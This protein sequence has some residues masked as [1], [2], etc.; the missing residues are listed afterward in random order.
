MADLTRVYDTPA[1]LAAQAA[2]RF[3]A[4]ASEAISVRGRFCVALAGGSTPKA[5][6]TDLSSRL[7]TALDWSKVE[8]YFGDERCVGPDHA[9]SNFLMTKTTLLAKLPIPTSNIHRIEGEKGPQA[10]AS[11]YET[12]LQ[13]RFSREDREAALDVTFLGMGG[14]G[15]TASLFPGHDFHAD[16]SRWVTTATAPP[17]SPIP[18]RVSL[19]IPFIARSRRV[20]FTIAGADKAVRLTEVMNARRAGAQKPPAAMVACRGDVEWLLDRAAAGLS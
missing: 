15:H 18:E 9:D 1:A 13:A 3:I 2:D 16:L 8:I 6:N 4:L 14:D 20:L 17:Q 12:L 7:A 11:A 19:T 10:A 5:M